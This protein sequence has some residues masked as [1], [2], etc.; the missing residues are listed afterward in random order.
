VPLAFIGQV[1]LAEAA[2]LTPGMLPASGVLSF[3]YD[4]EQR[5]WGFD[6]QDRGSS[7]VYWFADVEELRPAPLPE[8][9]PSHGRFELVSLTPRAS[10]SLPPYQALEVQALRLS[11]DEEDAYF[12]YRE[13]WQNQHGAG[14]QHQL[15]GHPS[16]VQDE[17][18]LECQLVSAGIYC[19]DS[20]GYSDPRRAELEPGAREWRLLAQID[21]DDAAEMMWGDVGMLYFWI[22]EPDLAAR[23]FDRA[24]MILQCS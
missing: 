11:A 2:A 24:W 5:A 22:R 19:G 14:P 13:E 12:A 20:T 3:F 4:P 9:L 16:P 18:Q 15:L 21:S 6:P 17:M 8:S 10:L 23:R 1:G 7:R